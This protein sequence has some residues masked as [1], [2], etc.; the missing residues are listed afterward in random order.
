MKLW[1]LSELCFSWLFKT[2]S[3]FTNLD[4][5]RVTLSKHNPL[6][7]TEMYNLKNI[8]AIWAIPA[9]SVKFHMVSTQDQSFDFAVTVQCYT[10]DAHTLWPNL[11]LARVHFLCVR[12]NIEI[13]VRLNCWSVVLVIKWVSLS[14][15]R[16]M[17]LS[18]YQ[19]RPKSVCQTRQ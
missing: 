17:L 1:L 18:V 11:L 4:W 10:H 6:T 16:D 12:P 14:L 5:G 7:V 19:T 15:C 9:R 13:R 8:S 2:I 3:K